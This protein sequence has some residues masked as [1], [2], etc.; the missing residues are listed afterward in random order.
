MKKIAM[1]V[2]TY[3][4][5]V[6]IDALLQHFWKIYLYYGIDIY[7]YDSSP[8]AETKKVIDKYKNIGAINLY[9]IKLSEDILPDDKTMLAFS[10]YG[11]ESEYQY[12][13]PIKDRTMY[14][15]N[16]LINIFSRIDKNYDA[17]ILKDVEYPKNPPCHEL[18]KTNYTDPVELYRDYSWLVTSLDKTI[19][20]SEKL[21]LL[22]GFSESSFRERYYIENKCYFPQTVFLFDALS[23]NSNCSVNV[24]MPKEAHS[25]EYPQNSIWRGEG[26]GIEIFGRYWPEVNNR[27]PHLYNDTKKEA[28][29]KETNLAVLFGS[30]D[31]LICIGFTEEKNFPEIEKMLSHW[32]DFS[33]LPI[34]KVQMVMKKDFDGL[35][36]SFFHDYYSCFKKEDVF[37]AYLEY[38]GNQWWINQTPIAKTEQYL[39]IKKEMELY[40]TVLNNA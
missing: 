2:F 35:C 25:Y 40:S 4:H 39:E 15:E 24:L 26:K 14:D 12:L 1:Q 6:A 27:L 11:L 9:Y 10:G 38:L 31:G 33:D 21:N 8:D 23:K 28:I 17:I 16:T 36:K 20:N 7:Y 30:V 29:K 3:K 22:K 19:F 34:E 18:T 13:W 32:E 5:A 37:S